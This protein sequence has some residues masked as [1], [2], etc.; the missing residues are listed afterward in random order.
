VHSTIL[1]PW[2]LIQLGKPVVAQPLKKFQ[3]LVTVYMSIPQAPILNQMNI[4]YTLPS[5][6]SE[7]HCNAVKPPFKVSFKEVKWNT[8]KS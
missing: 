5:Y 8:R 3:A 6:Y 2:S 1:S 4:F 7:L